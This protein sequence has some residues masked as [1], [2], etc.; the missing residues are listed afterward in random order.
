MEVIDLFR[1]P[2]I[3]RKLNVDNENIISKCLELKEESNGRSITNVGGWQSNHININL[4]EFSELFNIIY[5][6]SVDFSNFLELNLVGEIYSWANINKYKDFNMT[7]IHPNSVL[8]GVYYAKCPKNSGEI[9][10]H[11]PS[12]SIQHDW[13]S[14]INYNNYNSILWRID[15]EDG[16]FILFP[17][18]LY[19]HVNPNLNDKGDRISISFNVR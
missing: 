7:H 14:Q 8:S 15:P 1:V 12:P 17:S 5:H 4:E 3:K 9:V 10:F 6:I 13:V 2:I 18:W 16:D 19:H 11:H